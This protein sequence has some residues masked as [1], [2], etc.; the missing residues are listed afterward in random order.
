MKP[1][2]KREATRWVASLTSPSEGYIVFVSTSHFI[3]LRHRTNGNWIRVYIRDSK[4]E[5]WKN[6]VCI[7]TYPAPSYEEPDMF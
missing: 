1:D 3:A 6:G 5:M 7:K 2:V 4:A